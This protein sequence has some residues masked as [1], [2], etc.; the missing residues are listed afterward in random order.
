MYFSNFFVILQT[1]VV[2]V[3]Q[4]I[5]KKLLLLTATFLCIGCLK[6]QLIPQMPQPFHVYGIDYSIV[7]IYGEKQR[8]SNE[9]AEAFKNIN[10]LLISQP[11]NYNFSRMLTS[12]DRIIDFIHVDY[13]IDISPVLSNIA[14]GE[15]K[16]ETKTSTKIKTTRVD[17][18]KLIDGYKIDDTEGT[19]VVLIALQLD[20]TAEKASYDIVFFEPSTRE[21]L[22]V[23]RRTGNGRGR[24]LRNYWANSIQRCLDSLEPFR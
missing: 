24:G 4:Y 8:S 14:A 11:G 1:I 15:Y 19:G 2:P 21:I 23:Y 18:Q 7:K 6:A 12:S 22:A 5:M 3:N 10:L 16:T 9:F 20:K 17:L 13:N